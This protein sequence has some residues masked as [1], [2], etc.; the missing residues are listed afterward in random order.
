MSFSP[1]DPRLLLITWFGSGFL[2]P[3][4][5]TWGTLAALPFAVAIHTYGG[6][7]GLVTAAL[8]LYALSL[9]CIRWYEHKTGSHDSSRIVI[10]E[11]IGI[12]IALIPAYF[13]IIDYVAAF[14]LFRMF[15]A[16]KP[17]P[18]GWIDTHV[19]G[20]HGVLLDD[21]VAGIMTA[22]CIILV[23]GLATL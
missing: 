8:L 10:D 1:F 7:F 5:G 16:I 14:F 17:G 3:A 20:A 2:R 23:H 4:S 6:I 19:K 22:V 11:V 9:P 21:V 13:N 12:F 15:D 18:V